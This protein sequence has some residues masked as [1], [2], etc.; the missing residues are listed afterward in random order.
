MHMAIEVQPQHLLMWL[1][2]PGSISLS[3]MSMTA[4]AKAEALQMY[5]HFDSATKTDRSAALGMITTYVDQWNE[6]ELFGF[7]YRSNVHA[8]CRLFCPAPS[9]A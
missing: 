4:W 1:R 9:I 8:S 6:P 7:F 3:C 5:D 2:C